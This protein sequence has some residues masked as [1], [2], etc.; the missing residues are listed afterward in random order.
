[1]TKFAKRP[2]DLRK[3]GGFNRL[4]QSPD[5]AHKTDTRPLRGGHKYPSTTPTRGSF[6][7]RAQAEGPHD[8][9]APIEQS[10]PET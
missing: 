6:E 10:K 2:S 7:R 9:F 3:T 5:R 4:C 1:M 8:F